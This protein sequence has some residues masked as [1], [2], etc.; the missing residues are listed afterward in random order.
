MFSNSPDYSLNPSVWT[1]C[2][3]VTLD[4]QFN[5]EHLLL[6][7]DTGAFNALADTVWYNT[8]AWVLTGSAN[9]SQ[10][11]ARFIEVWFIDAD[12]AMNPN[13]NY[14]QMSGGPAGQVGTHTGV[15]YALRRL[16]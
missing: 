2:P 10:L 15:L 4:G 6:V 9:Y 5:P 13:L 14:A 8:M 7:N 1:T 12:T 3:Y 11:A 16:T